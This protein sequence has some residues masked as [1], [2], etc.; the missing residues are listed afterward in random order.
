MAV[1]LVFNLACVAAD[2]FSCLMIPSAAKTAN[3]QLSTLIST[4]FSA[5]LWLAY[6]AKSRRV[7]NTFVR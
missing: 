5:I 3:A 1:F 6:L 4:F 2:H 7:K